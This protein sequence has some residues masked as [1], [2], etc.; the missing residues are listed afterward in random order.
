MCNKITLFELLDQG[1]QS[2]S[3]TL[4]EVLICVSGRLAAA[5]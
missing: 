1:L 5:L 2:C 4:D 3:S